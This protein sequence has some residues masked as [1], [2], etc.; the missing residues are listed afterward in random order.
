[1]DSHSAGPVLNSASDRDEAVA[2]LLRRHG[3]SPTAQRLA[4][5]RVLFEQA[6]HFSAEEVY[7]RLNQTNHRVSKATVYNT[8]GLLVAKGLVREVLVD[9]EKVFYDSN[10]L[11]HHHLY[12]VATG[13]LTDIALAD[14]S[15]NG[16]PALP[17]GTVLEGVDVI[18]RVRSR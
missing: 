13:R 7:Q 10:T 9:R 2:G 17:D 5:A 18:L 12:D 8:L 16:L 14:V 6:A 11:P 3:V 15:V 1:M 4:I